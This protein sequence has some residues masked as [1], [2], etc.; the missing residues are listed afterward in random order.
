MRHHKHTEKA[1]NGGHTT[2]NEIRAGNVCLKFPRS[3]TKNTLE[4]GAQLG[5]DQDKLRLAELS[6]QSNC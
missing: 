2:N 3:R 4:A 1:A 6:L 5:K